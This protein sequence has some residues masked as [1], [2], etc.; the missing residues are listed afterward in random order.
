MNDQISLIQTIDSLKEYIKQCN[1][2][3]EQ[4]KK[5]QS[6]PIEEIKIEYLQQIEVLKQKGQD[7]I[8]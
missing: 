5:T 2:M 4:Q 1:D 7:D 8:E 6:H 3:I